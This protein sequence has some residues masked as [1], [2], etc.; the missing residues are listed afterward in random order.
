MMNKA[1]EE[2]VPIGIDT[3]HDERIADQED[4]CGADEGAIDAALAASG[5]RRRSRS[6]R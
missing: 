3:E 4:Q 5:W 1:D 6:R 2:I